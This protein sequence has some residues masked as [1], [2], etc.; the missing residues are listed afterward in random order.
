MKNPLLDLEGLPPFSQIKPEHVEPAINRLLTSGREQIAAL[1]DAPGPFTWDNLV[2]AL[3]RIDDRLGRAWSPVS[4][5]NSVVNSEALRQAYNACLPKLS[6]Y[7][8]EVGQ[9]E[10]LFNAYQE[11]AN[12]D[13]GLDQPQRKL[14][15]NTL[16]DFHLSGV[17]LP[18]AEKA[19][20]KEISQQLSSLASQ[21]EENLLDA[22]NNW[23]KPITQREQLAGLPQSALDLA[24]QTAR[25]RGQQEG[26]MLTL[27]FPSYMPVMTYADNRELR[28]ELYQAYSTRAS[29]Q[30]PDGGR[31]DNTEIMD[32]ILALR[33]E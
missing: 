33:H 2:A 16:R 8:T 14:L 26:W 32:Q 22:T 4:H 31:W 21:F 25:E 9:N 19:R 6:E 5:M 11:V 13:E 12:N 7:A 30:G 24:E 20:Y 18:P 3:E 23:S 1:L 10:R 27:D 17:D 29:D 15:K 28:E